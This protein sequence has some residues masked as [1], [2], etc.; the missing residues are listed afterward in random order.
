MTI[1]KGEE[2]GRV[3]SVPSGCVPATDEAELHRLLNAGPLPRAIGLLGG[4]LG[5]TVSASAD[6]ERLTEGSSAVL[7]TIDLAEVHHDHGRHRVAAHAVL[8]RSWWWGPV[9]VIANAQFIGDWDV[10]PRSHPND[11]WLDVTEVDRR[12]SVGQR[13]AARRRLPS[14]THTPHPLISTSRLREG[15]WEF[16]R[17]V[18][19]WLDGVRVGS[20]RTLRVRV[21][22]DALPVCF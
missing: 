1:R 3:G 14:G 7:A 17:A 16:A 22:P 8:R 6:R 18:P 13:L 21:L 20:T 4:D 15:E 12:M 19:L 2:W 9:L 10:A 5:R 11:G